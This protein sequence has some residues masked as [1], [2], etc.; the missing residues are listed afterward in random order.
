[1]NHRQLWVY[2]LPLRSD[3]LFCV[4][5]A[6]GVVCTVVILLDGGRRGAVAVVLQP[7]MAFFAGIIIVSVVGGSVREWKIGRQGRQ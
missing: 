2:R 1:M 4:S 7:L 5:I 3:P 6:F